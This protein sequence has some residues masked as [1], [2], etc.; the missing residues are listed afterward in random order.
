MHDCI[1]VGGG[2]IGMLSARMLAEAGRSVL[3]LERGEPGRESSWAGG[4]ILSPLY[5]WRY[6][7]PVN[8]LATWSQARYEALCRELH[9][10][11]GIDPQWTRSGL[12]MIEPEDGEDGLAWGRAHRARIEALTAEAARRVEPALATGLGGGLWMPEIA[13]LRNPR[14]LQALRCSLALRGVELR[15]GHAVE[16]VLQA[17]GRVQGVRGPWGEARAGQVLVAGGAWSAALVALP[18]GEPLPVAPVRGQ[19]ILYRTE[20]GTLRRILLH[21]G[22]YLIPRRDGHIVVGSTMERVGFDKSTTEQA[23]D[24]LR[25]AAE[26]LVPALRGAPIVRHWAGLR[27]GSPQGVPFIG[28]H[29]DIRG[30]FVNAGHFRNGVV[31]GLAA[32]ALVRA[33]MNGEKPPLNENPYQLRAGLPKG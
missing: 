4:G 5:P 6:P 2:L 22:R 10:E 19:M 26:R 23:H 29:P 28:A 33:L 9:E 16:E 20:P 25:A 24:E 17:A 27:P 30:L 7:E 32:C 15:S 1:V 21:E 3:L 11:T 18:G 12:L 13:Q 31:M 8:A 14:M